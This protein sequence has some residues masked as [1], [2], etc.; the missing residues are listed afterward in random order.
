MA[1][2]D[3]F[4]A[5]KAETATYIKVLETDERIRTNDLNNLRKEIS[6]FDG[7]I[8]NQIKANRNW[9]YASEVI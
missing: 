1:A 5:W 9:N 7:K 6:T 3:E 8:E 2:N 4:T